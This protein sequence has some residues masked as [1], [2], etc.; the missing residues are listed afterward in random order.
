MNIP[1]PPITLAKVSTITTAKQFSDLR[2][3]Q[4]KMA[5]EGHVKLIAHL[6][7]TRRGEEM[8]APFQVR[9]LIRVLSLYLQYNPT[10]SQIK[11]ISSI[12]SFVLRTPISQAFLDMFVTV[13]DSLPNIFPAL[14]PMKIST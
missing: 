2:R 13:R 6:F 8:G 9:R 5:R 12:K 3:Q 14:D 1:N 7:M 11:A 10:L 4:G